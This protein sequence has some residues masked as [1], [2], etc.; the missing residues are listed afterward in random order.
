MPCPSNSV[1]MTWNSGPCADDRGVGSMWLSDFDGSPVRIYDADVRADEA[2]R[3]AD[4]PA[5]DERQ[6]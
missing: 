3:L 4:D 2:E 5:G 1:R 6:A